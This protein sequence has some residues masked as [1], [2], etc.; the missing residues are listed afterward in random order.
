[1]RVGSYHHFQIFRVWGN[2]L[3]RR[4]CL[5]VSK[6]MILYYFNHYK[7]SI[8]N[9]QN[10]FKFSKTNNIKVSLMLFLYN[11]YIYIYMYNI[12]YVYFRKSQIVL[13][14]HEIAYY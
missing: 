9:L 2:V 1:M 6:M 8:M 7:N 3:W 11:V 13:C 10:S 12:M 5:I 14:L 4:D